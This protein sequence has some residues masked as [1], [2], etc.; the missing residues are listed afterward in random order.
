MLQSF[1]W[2]LLILWLWRML[3]NC[4]LPSVTLNL[5]SS[6][7]FPPSSPFKSDKS[8]SIFS[9]WIKAAP[10]LWSQFLPF[11]VPF[12]D[13]MLLLLRWSRGGENKNCIQ[14][15]ICERSVD[16]SGGNE[17]SCFILYFCLSNSYDPFCFFDCCRALRLQSTL[18]CGTYSLGIVSC[19]L[20]N[21][22]DLGENAEPPPIHTW[23]NAQGVCLLGGGGYWFSRISEGWQHALPFIRCFSGT[24]TPAP[25]SS[26]VR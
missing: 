1:S 4:P 15:S 19:L 6:F 12:L 22:A 2:C 8:Q 7:S 13:I 20:M 25:G 14:N 10:Y 5:V 23:N 9:P 18:K 16:L 11:S 26:C 17:G 24:W 3:S 21:S